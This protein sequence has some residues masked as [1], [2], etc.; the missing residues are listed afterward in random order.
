MTYEVKKDGKTYYTTVCDR[1]PYTK[2][3]E[4]TMVA[5]GYEI[6][7]NGRMRRKST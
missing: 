6:Y 3:E 1:P 4:K 7:I 2:T 5:A